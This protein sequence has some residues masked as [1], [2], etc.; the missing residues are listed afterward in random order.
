[1]V[2]F[3]K[4]NTRI[5]ALLDFISKFN[6]MSL[7]YAAV[8]KPCICLI[9]VGTPKIDRSMLSTHGMVLANFQVKD[10]QR[11]IRFFQKTFLVVNTAIK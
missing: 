11:R 8:L 5:Q 6:A 2:K 7:A 3:K 10:K 9:N 1:M 4:S